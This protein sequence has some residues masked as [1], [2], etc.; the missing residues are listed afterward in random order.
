MERTFVLVSAGWPLAAFRFSRAT[1]ST[2]LVRNVKLLPQHRPHLGWWQNSDSDL[3]ISYQEQRCSHDALLLPLGHFLG[4]GAGF[5]GTIPEQETVEC[6]VERGRGN[7]A[8]LENISSRGE[9]RK[10][11]DIQKELNDYLEPRHLYTLE[12]I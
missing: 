12:F 7:S 4:T 2:Y 10:G 6:V 3:T 1:D 11:G 8:C 9:A 5:P